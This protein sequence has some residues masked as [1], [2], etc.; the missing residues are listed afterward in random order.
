MKASLEQD[1]FD[2]SR[3]S[4]VHNAI[5]TRKYKNEGHRGYLSSKTGTGLKGP[6]IGSVGRLS[7]EKGHADFIEAIS[8]V[9]RQGYEADFVLVGDGPEKEALRAQIRRLGLEGRVHLPGYLDDMPGVYQDLDLMVL[10][11]YTEGLPNVVL[12]SLAMGVPVIATRVGG[13][14][15]II[16]DDVSGVLIEPNSPETLAVKI[17]EFLDSRERFHRMAAAGRANVIANFD[18]AART[19][20]IETIYEELASKAG[21]K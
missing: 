20:R 5:V 2:P 16:S 11:S 19:R 1:G 12:E 21:R 7:R 14:P 18:F 4:L 17:A 9:V 3:L 8:L 15:D 13:T 6:I 10:P